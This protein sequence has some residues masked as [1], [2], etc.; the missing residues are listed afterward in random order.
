MMGDVDVSP[1]DV[2]ENLVCEA[3]NNSDDDN[4]LPDPNDNVEDAI[5]DDRRF[6]H[7]NQ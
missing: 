2:A 4:Q 6:W 5:D 3:E 7:G 1:D